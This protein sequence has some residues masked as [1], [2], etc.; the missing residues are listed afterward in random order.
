MMSQMSRRFGPVL[1]QAAHCRIPVAGL[2]ATTN[3]VGL[4]VVPNAPEV[5]ST[6][7]TQQLEDLKAIPS[8]AEYRINVEKIANYR[9]K[10]VAE[11]DSTDVDAAINAVEAEVG[12][13]VEEMIKEA[14]AE[15]RLI[16][17]MAEW[18]PWESAPVERCRQK[19]WRTS[20]R[21][22]PCVYSYMRV[23][24]ISILKG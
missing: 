24:P 19:L 2:K 13:Q 21:R 8:T 20:N 16:P 5:L 17:K 1:R 3:L 7:Y 11:K 9:L 6:L 14:E 15:L 18:K 10:L 23:K 12:L 4:D 22:V